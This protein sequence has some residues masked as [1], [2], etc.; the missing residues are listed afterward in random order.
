MKRATSPEVFKNLRRLMV[1]FIPGMVLTFYSVLR[2]GGQLNGLQ[3]SQVSTTSAQNPVHVGLDLL[4]G[5]VGVGFQKGHCLHDLARVAIP[6][7]GCLGL[8]PRLLDG[9]FPILG[10][11]FNGSDLLSGCH[12]FHRQ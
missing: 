1:G 4:T 3:Y 2:L 9:M 11:P 10:Q 12:P 6:A 5:G 7:L 8:D